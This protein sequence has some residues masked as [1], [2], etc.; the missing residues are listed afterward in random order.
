MTT[1]TPPGGKDFKPGDL[2]TLR[3]G[4]PVMTLIRFNA[5]GEAYCVWFVDGSPQASTFPPHALEKK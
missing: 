1:T 3:S 4:G 2:V 5:D